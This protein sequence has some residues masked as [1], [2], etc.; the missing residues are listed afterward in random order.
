[1]VDGDIL[2]RFRRDLD[3]LVP[4]GTRIGVAVSGGPDSLALLLLAAEAR[5]GEIDAATVDHG[6]RPESR[7]EAEGV[8]S[9]CKRLGVPHAVLTLE[10]DALPT[11]A[12]Q[13]R[14]RAAR[15]KALA[16]WMRK[17]A[18][19]TLLTG[20]HLDDQAETMVMRL[21]RGSGVAGLAG[22]RPTATVPDAPDLQLAR[23]LLN[24][25]RSDLEAL[26][27]RAGE[28]PAKDPGNADRRHERV[29]IRQSLATSDLLQA[30]F[31]VRSASNL[32]LA[33][34]ALSWAT[35]REWDEAV[36][37]EGAA[38]IYSSVHAPLE[39]RRRIATRAIA[40]LATE[41]DTQLR[42][43]ELDRLFASLMS[44]GTATLRGVRC[45]GGSTWRFAAGK[46]RK[47]A[48]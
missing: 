6:F 33:D 30:E 23:P 31:L 18:L 37:H 12:I 15:Y 16:K 48:K 1:M 43:R 27:A 45:E 47:L 35:D 32:A 41:G 11:A 34:E 24:W 19:T 46:P 21:N 26:C 40:L 9:T 2:D 7:G 17:R 5:P 29:R 20:H 39:I 22:M 36:E 42:G 44:G 25:R 4:A 8:A 38:I 14:A 28:M 13:E 3:A 10:W